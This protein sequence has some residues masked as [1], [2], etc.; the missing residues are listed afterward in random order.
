MTLRFSR[1]TIS[2]IWVSSPTQTNAKLKKTVLNILAIP[3]SMS[4]PFSF[5]RKRSFAW[6]IL[7]TSEAA[8]K[9]IIN[10]GNFSQT[11]P[12]EG[13]L[14]PFSP[15][16]ERYKA[17][18]KATKPIKT[19]WAPLIITACWFDNSLTI[20]LEAATP[21]VVSMV[22]PIQAPATSCITWGSSNRTGRSRWASQGII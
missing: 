6:K 15:R 1:E 4:F 16:V 14:L 18:K 11:I 13:E 5:T 12:R 8:T 7:N 3:G 9:P 10:F 20:A 19:F 17:I 22:P 2:F 21:L